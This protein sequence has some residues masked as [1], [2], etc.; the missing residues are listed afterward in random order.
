MQDSPI[1]SRGNSSPLGGVCL[2][3]VKNGDCRK[4]GLTVRQFQEAMKAAYYNRDRERGLMA[5][6]AWLV[7]EV[8]ELAE[9]LLKGDKRASMEELA[10]VV[11]WTFSLANLLGIDMEEA[12][13]RKYRYDIEKVLKP[14]SRDMHKA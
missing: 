6:F 2:K 7:E 1:R 14:G 11:A 4:E 9:T 3:L 5:T 10:D 12:L 13:R 8:G